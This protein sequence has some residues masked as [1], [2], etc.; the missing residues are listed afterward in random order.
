MIKKKFKPLFTT[1]EI[2][3]TETAIKVEQSKSE[4][5]QEHIQI[6]ERPVVCKKC[7]ADFTTADVL[8]YECFQFSDRV[9]VYCPVCV[10][11]N[12]IKKVMTFDRSR[13]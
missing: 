1:E 4:H 13:K 2:K 12:K 5:A 9:V 10:T 6:E 7:G 3:Q 11:S 8:C